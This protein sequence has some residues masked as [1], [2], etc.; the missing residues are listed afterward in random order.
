MYWCQ[1]NLYISLWLKSC[2]LAH[3]CVRLHADR[4]PLMNSC[5]KQCKTGTCSSRCSPE[6]S[7]FR[8]PLCSSKLFTINSGDAC[9]LENVSA[10][11]LFQSKQHMCSS[12]FQGYP[13]K[14][15]LQYFCGS[16]DIT[17]IYTSVNTVYSHK[18]HLEKLKIT[19]GLMKESASKAYKNNDVLKNELSAA[20]YHILR[21][22]PNRKYSRRRRLTDLTWLLVI[23]WW[24]IRQHPHFPPF[25]LT[26]VVSSCQSFG[27]QPENGEERC[28]RKGLNTTNFGMKCCYQ[29]TTQADA[30]WGRLLWRCGI[31]SRK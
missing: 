25:R 5:L 22:Q 1:V 23:V 28:S 27:M 31:D 19:A 8:P 13:A 14:L 26:F 7:L 21:V 9:L 6:H 17:C 16:K 10:R 2:W 29:N 12:Q 30:I 4:L 24:H 11:L 20:A 3:W 18:L 15:V